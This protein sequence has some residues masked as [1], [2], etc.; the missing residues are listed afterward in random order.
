MD[1]DLYSSVAG[2]NAF[3]E[4]NGCTA[5]NVANINTDNYKRKIPHVEQDKNGL[6]ETKV[7]IDNTPG[8]ENPR[9]VGEPEGPSRE[10]S[11]VNYAEGS[12][13]HD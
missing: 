5:H 8:L 6:P 2:I 3:F 9:R 10:M 13:E 7:T 12:G 1:L 4:K 11:N